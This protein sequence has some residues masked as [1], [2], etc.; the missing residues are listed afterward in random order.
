MSDT[1]SGQLENATF[2]GGCFWCVESDFSKLEGVQTVVSGYTGGS[3]E[4]PS[5][6]QVCGG[7]TGHLE[8]VQLSYDPAII[9]YEQLLDSFW[10]Q[11]DPCD[12]G[13]QYVDRGRQYTSAIFFH[14][15]EQQQAAERSRDAL[16]A[17]GRFSAPIMTEIRE[18]SR[19]WPAE[20]YHQNFCS[21]SPQHYQNYRSRSGR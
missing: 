18:A 12:G 4:N 17:S 2:A 21:K 10:G 6:E 1:P 8:A 5:Y 15:V 11:I 19:F 3:E 9:S 7:L 20:E 14:S 13:G 16:Q